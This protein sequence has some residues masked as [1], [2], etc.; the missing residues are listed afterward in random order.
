MDRKYKLVFNDH[1]LQ[2][3]ITY[4]LVTKFDLEPSVLRAE[5]DDNGGMMIVRLRGNEENIDNSVRYLNEIGVE[6]VLLSKHIY[7]DMDKCIDC[8][9]CVSICPARAFSID[10]DTWDI[11][12]NFERCIACGSCLTACPTHAVTLSI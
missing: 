11:D 9:S 5:I 8:G 10:K 12:L 3:S 4:A 7:R 2:E 6:T 1:N